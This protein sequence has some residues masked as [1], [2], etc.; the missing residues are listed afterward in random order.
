MELSTRKTN[1]V[2]NRLHKVHCRSF[3]KHQ[4]DKLRKINQP[5]V[6]KELPLYYIP[7]LFLRMIRSSPSREKNENLFPLLKRGFPTM[8][9]KEMKVK[10]KVNESW[11]GAGGQ[12]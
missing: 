8:E 12:K 3:S 7:I 2:S 11:R 9:I 10:V 1:L 5:S 6:L 4:L